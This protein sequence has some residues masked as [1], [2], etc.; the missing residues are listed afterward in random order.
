MNFSYPAII[1]LWS[2]VIFSINVIAKE[3]AIYRWVDENNVVHFSQNLP[4]GTNYTELTT[5]SSFTSK[6]KALAE[7]GK[8]ANID[9][10]ISQYEQEQA[11]VIAK[12]KEIADK[13]CKAAKYNVTTLDSFDEVMFTDADGKDRAMTAKEKKEKLALSKK[14]IE[15]YCQKENDKK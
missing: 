3:T 14:H 15:L 2:A 7:T 4:K 5:F 10:Q 6:G 12:N 9:Q 11:E 1:V 13:N 8:S